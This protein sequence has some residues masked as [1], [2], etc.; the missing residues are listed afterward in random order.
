METDSKIL[1]T[2]LEIATLAVDI[3]RSLQDH[4]YSAPYDYRDNK[5]TISF[6]FASSESLGRT[7]YV[8]VYVRDGVL[9]KKD[10][11]VLHVD[12]E[13]RNVYVFRPGQWVDYLYMLMKKVEKIRMKKA[14]E[15]Q[16]KEKSAHEREQNFKA[17]D[18]SG[19][20]K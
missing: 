15:N 8:K 20:F 11:L 1:N 14:S 13:H 17:I 4:P 12:Q 16:F 2:A 18:D 9:F 7:S 5:I 6:Y 19:I 10:L 3:G